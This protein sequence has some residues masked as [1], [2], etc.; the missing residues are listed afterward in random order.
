MRENKKIR[1]RLRCPECGS[2]DVIKWGVRKGLATSV[3]GCD[4]QS[5]DQHHCDGYGGRE[6][7]DGLELSAGQFGAPVWSPVIATGDLDHATDTSVAHGCSRSRVWDETFPAASVQGASGEARWH[8]SICN[9]GE[10]SR[11]REGRTKDSTFRT[12]GPDEER[13][14]MLTLHDRQF[15]DK[16]WNIFQKNGST[17]SS[18]NSIT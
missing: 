13:E 7:R 1:R 6:K 2:L 4:A 17:K 15:A 10:R 3:K 14:I 5:A 16:G 8:R 12:A 11:A 9:A 18:R